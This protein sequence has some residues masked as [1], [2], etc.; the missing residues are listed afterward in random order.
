MSPKDTGKAA[1]HKNEERTVECPGEGCDEE[2]L[3]RGLY[4]HVMRS[5]GNGHGSKNEVPEYINLEEA[6]TAGT[7]EVEM[8]Y[9]EE[10]DSE[11]VARLCPYCKRPFRGKQG[12]MIHLGQMAGRKDHP[13][14]PREKHDAEDFSIVQVDEDE[15][16][17]EVIKESTVMSSTERPRES[18][19]PID[20][21]TVRKH[22]EDLREQGLEEEAERA[23]KRLL[24]GQ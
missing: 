6:K 8:E 3:A 18:N 12:V 1:K 16:I 22:I 11:S 24:G 21:E 5:S 14:K 23:K 9:P 10:R 20:E 19:E 13:K 15:N 7:R 4:L 17:V 2:P